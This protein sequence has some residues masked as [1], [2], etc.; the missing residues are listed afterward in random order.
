MSYGFFLKKLKELNPDD[1]K[2]LRSLKIKI[3][4]EKMKTGD[5]ATY[6]TAHKRSIVG[7]ATPRTGA[8]TR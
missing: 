8:S 1:D 7:K 2:S 4:D 6:K 5:R 3:R